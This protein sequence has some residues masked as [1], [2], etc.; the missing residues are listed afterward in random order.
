[1]AD[2]KIN[3]TT[4]RMYQ[5]RD[6]KLIDGFETE[7]FLT[8]FGTTHSVKTPTDDPDMIRKAIMDKIDNVRKIHALSEE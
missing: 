5:L 7:F 6:G 8:E 1:M 4:G 2:F 3:Y